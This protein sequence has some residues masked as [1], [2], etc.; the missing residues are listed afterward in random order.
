MCGKEGRREKMEL[1]ISRKRRK[2]KADEEV[3]DGKRV[4]GGGGGGGGRREEVVRCWAQ[5]CVLL[6]ILG[7]Q[8]LVEAKVEED[9]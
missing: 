9:V 1:G 7:D 6:E 3:D 5:Q 8:L 4:G 2:E